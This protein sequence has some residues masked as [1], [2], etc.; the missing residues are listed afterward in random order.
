M[1]HPD[2]YDLQ[3]TVDRP[4]SF[5][6]DVAGWARNFPASVQASISMG[7]GAWPLAA[8]RAINAGIRDP[9]RLTDLAF[10]MHVPDLGGQAIPKRH[11]RSSDWIALWTSLRDDV[12]AMLRANPPGTKPGGGG[13]AQPTPFTNIR[14]VWVHT[15]TRSVVGSSSRATHRRRKLC[16]LAPTDIM[17]GTNDVASAHAAHRNNRAF[18]TYPNARLSPALHDALDEL[19][20]CGAAIHFMSWI[21]PRARYC[22][23][24]VDTMFDLCA[25]TGARSLML[26]AEEPWMRRAE[27]G[28]HATFVD[29]V[30]KPL[31]A[32]RPCCVGVSHIVQ[33]S[34]TKLGPLIAACDYIVPQAYSSSRPGK[35]PKDANR[36]WGSTGKTMV[37]GLSGMRKVSLSGMITDLAVAD[38]LGTV[39]E[40]YYWSFGHLRANAGRFKVAQDAAA[41]AR[42]TRPHLPPPSLCHVPWPL[43]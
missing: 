22:R 29:T 34:K 42:A 14:R 33:G 25:R 2:A 12:G 15:N 21:I 39:R 26:D 35:L 28:R 40:V 13:T 17:I 37:M 9:N 18:S 24:L 43:F 4:D 19:K 10:W 11:S 20:S 8:Q 23:G 5:E 27:G 7:G 1:F 38:S 32:G 6:A 31:I 16:E 41:R 3:A 36:L 30:F